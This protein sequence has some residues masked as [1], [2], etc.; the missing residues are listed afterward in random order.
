[1][2]GSSNPSGKNNNIVNTTIELILKIGALFLVVYLCFRIIKPFLS[3]LLWGLIIA[4]ILFPLFQK[5]NQ[6][7]GK[8]YKLS[9]LLIMIVSL[10][11]LVLPSIWLVNQLVD[12]VK[13]LAD[14][15][16]ADNLSIPAPSETVRE[17]PLIGQWLYENWLQLSQ[18]MGESV[19]GF[20]PQ[21]T[22]WGEKVLGAF[23]NTGI[24][25]LQFAVSIIM[26]GVF[27]MFFEKGS[28]SGR[29]I[30]NKIVGERGEEFLEISLL[31]I[32]NVAAGILGVAV[33]QTTLMG[34]GLILADI[35]LAAVW[36]IV[37]LIMTIAQIPVLLFNIPL[38]IYLFAFRDPLPAALWSVYFVLMGLT[39]NYLKP[40]IMG[41][42]ANVPMLVIFIGAIGGFMAFGFIGLFLGA[43]I[44]SLAYKLYITWISYE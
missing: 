36:I 26:A 43:I 31:T 23:A 17:W 14:Q 42:G 11:L 24:G 4:I 10:S 32:R 29:R 13:F 30:F 18:N 8:R 2:A 21:I 39:D 34:V 6:W 33:I 1:M 22:S 12:G 5:L 44:L 15:V 9:S 41:K 40:L 28:E 20:M 16:V 35:P 7:F 27:L 38:V 37:I 25:I 19:K 3:I